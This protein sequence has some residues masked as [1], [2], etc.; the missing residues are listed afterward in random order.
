MKDKVVIITG[1]TSGIGYACARQFAQL[2]S[3][4]CIAARNEEKLKQICG[5]LNQLSGHGMYVKT[6]VGVE[7]E[8]RILIAETVKRYGKIDILINNAGISMRALLNDVSLEVIHKVMNIN[9]W[10]TVYCTKFAL[11]YI[12]QQQGSVVGISSI[13]GKKGLPARCGYSASKFAMEGFLESVR[14]ENLKKNLHVLVA[15]PGY[16]ASNIRNAA[17][18]E[19]GN[20]QQESPLEESKLMQ[21][22][23]VAR[24]VY[25][26]VANRKRDL[27][28]TLNGKLTV[29]LNKFFPSMMDKIV[30]NYVAQEPDSPF[31]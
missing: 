1:A 25:H 23:A 8:C 14:I 17:L 4:V 24:A 16:T 27:V 2:G 21:P 10:G 18:N 6:D 15:A 11:P 5:E 30:Y 20:A 3:K 7:D 22:E 28:L 13:A 29:W 31:K 19:N 12:L 9:F 26:A